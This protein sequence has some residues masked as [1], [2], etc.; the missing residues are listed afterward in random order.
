MGD[1]T[2]GV[3]VGRFSQSEIDMAERCAHY[4]ECIAKVSGTT[5]DQ[6][7]LYHAATVLRDMQNMFSG[8]IPSIDPM[9]AI[10]ADALD[11]AGIRYTTPSSRRQHSGGLDFRLEGYGVEIEVK[12]FHSSRISEQMASATDVIAV[13]GR[14]AVKFLAN[15]IRSQAQ[16]KTSN[17]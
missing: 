11:S 6:K 12:Q 3:A 14:M 17:L 1:E 4:L 15:L 13:Q 2:E 5:L 8:I 16:P 9:E 10:I 7:T